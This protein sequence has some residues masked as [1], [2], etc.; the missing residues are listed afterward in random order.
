MVGPWVI[1]PRLIDPRTIRKRVI[2]PRRRI[3]VRRNRSTRW[4]WKNGDRNAIGD[5]RVL[6]QRGE[7]DAQSDDTQKNYFSLHNEYN[8]FI[9]LMSSVCARSDWPAAVRRI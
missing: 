4:I 1:C 2:G 6:R 7:G 9:S 8:R 5:N 3:G